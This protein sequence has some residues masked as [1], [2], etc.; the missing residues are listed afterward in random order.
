MKRKV[1][2]SCS[3]FIPPIDYVWGRLRSEFDVR[4]SA[5]GNEGEILQSD[6]LNSS[7]VYIFL[8]SDYEFPL[9]SK[10]KRRLSRVL[11]LANER[12]RNSSKPFLLCFSL[13]SPLDLV[14]SAKLT[15]DIGEFML[16]IH[17]LCQIYMHFYVINLDS[18]LIEEGLQTSFSARNW[19]LSHSRLSIRAW[20]HISRGVLEVFTRIHAAPKKL[21]L[22]D[23][24]NTLWGGVIGEDGIENIALGEEGY[25]RVFRDLTYT[26]RELYWHWSVRITRRMY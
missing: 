13:Y 14:S 2:L 19:Y 15:K 18:L 17:K 5:V 3:S 21:L 10:K 9:D 12:L 7:A 23:A 24:D 1:I 8:L 25:G 6:N 4:F 20:E 22:L 26:T 16:E 11:E